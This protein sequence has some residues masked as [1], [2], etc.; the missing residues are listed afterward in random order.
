MTD[1]LNASTG[2]N[3][4][5]QKKLKQFVLS[6]SFDSGFGLDLMVK[7]LSIA[8][9]I[10]RDNGVPVPFSAL[11]R[12]LWAN[13]AAMLGEGQDHTAIAKLSE[14][15]AGVTLSCGKASVTP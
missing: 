15:L 6:R 2:M 9:Q 4:T 10:G 7:D 13:A 11:C 5:T 12:E 8:L 3:N 14:T 1:V